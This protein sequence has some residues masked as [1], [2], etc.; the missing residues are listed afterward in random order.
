[1][2][3]ETV[4]TEQY[5]E[6]AVAFLAQRLQAREMGKPFHLFLSG[7][8]TPKPIYRGLAEAGLDW[9]NVHLWLGDERYVPWDH[10][11]SN[12]RMAKEA[13]IEPAGIPSEQTHPWPI[14]A[15]P[16]LS[17]ETYDR[18][19][20]AV[21]ERDGQSLHLQILG[22][23]DDGHTASLFPDS[24][25]LAERDAMCVPNVVSAQEKNRLTLTFPALALSKEV[26]FLIKG[27][28]KANVVK[29]VIEDGLH[30]SAQVRGQESTVFFLDQGAAARLTS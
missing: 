8:S 11:D 5:T 26:V 18:E 9:S 1:M 25:A 3:I 20:R 16:E 19:F 14:L 23:G 29:E 10:P 27:G 7:G 22:M 12:F 4:P 13:L 2:I 15:S 6:R 30:P 28:N 21:F 17:G 24:P